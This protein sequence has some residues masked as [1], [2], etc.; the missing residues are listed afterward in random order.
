MIMCAYV[1]QSYMYPVPAPQGWFNLWIAKSSS[2]L[3]RSK[4][5]IK[6]NFRWNGELPKFES[7]HFG[8]ELCGTWTTSWKTCSPRIT[9]HTFWAAIVWLRF[10]A[11][12]LK[13]YEKPLNA[14]YQTYTLH[15]YGRY[16]GWFVL[17]AANPIRIILFPST[18]SQVVRR[19]IQHDDSR[20]NKGNECDGDG[21]TV[22]AGSQPV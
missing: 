6:M 21:A 8:P 1:K 12:K 11:A 22:S 16:V 10:T 18:E 4:T 13:L 9:L 5:K 19:C 20:T 2:W 14:N 7:L 3:Q 17:P 15:R